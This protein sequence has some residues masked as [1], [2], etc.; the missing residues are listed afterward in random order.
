MIASA[1]W[2]TVFDLAGSKNTLKELE[3]KTLTPGFWDDADTARSI[4]MRISE[5]KEDIHLWESLM[6]DAEALLELS[7]ESKEDSEELEERFGELSRTFEAERRRLFFSSPHDKGNAVL[8]VY[9][10][11]GG[12]D[13]EDWAAILLNMFEKY[14]EKKKWSVSTLHMHAGEGKGIKNATI[15]IKGKFA[16]GHLKG[17]AGVHRLVRISPFSAKKL[18]HTSFVMV[19]VLPELI[20]SD[21]VNIRP[22]DMEITFARSSG[23]GGQNVNKRETAVRAKHIPT[24]IQ[25]HVES[26]RSQSANRERAIELLR[27][28]LFQ[29]MQEQEKKTLEELSAAQSAEAEWGH[30]IRSYVFHPYKMVKDHR[31]GVETSDVENVLD[32]DISEFIQ[33]EIEGKEADKDEKE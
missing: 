6:G 23:P 4:T 17:E 25:V 15:E 19:E 32:G 7:G 9:A 28:K 21:E 12:D 22:E 11:A 2:R 30:Q 13:A 24:G 33:A 14:A 16:Y 26:G 29:R 1:V 3:Q 27:S 18:R 5:L 31:T 20:I 8:S 10:G